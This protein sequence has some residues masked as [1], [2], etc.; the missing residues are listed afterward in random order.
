[1]IYFVQDASSGPIKI[2]HSGD[3]DARL[4]E[5]EIRYGRPLFLLGS[6]P[7]GSEEEQKI[8]ARFAHLRFGRTEQFRPEPEIFEFIANP[9]SLEAMKPKS[10]IVT[11]I[12]YKGSDDFAAWVK[13]LTGHVNL[14]MTNTFDMALKVYAESVGFAETQPKRQMK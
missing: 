1:M 10:P 9:C 8:H 13:R 7:G 4:H 5:L 6:L 2:G 3:V 12:A 14:P 11:I